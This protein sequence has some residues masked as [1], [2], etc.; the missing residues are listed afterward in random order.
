[1]KRLRNGVA[2]IDNLIAVIL[3]QAMEDVTTQFDKVNLVE[4]KM[5]RPFYVSD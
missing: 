1:M 4:L 3:P 5:I 2:L